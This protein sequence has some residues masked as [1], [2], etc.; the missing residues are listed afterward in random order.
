MHG[1]SV[2]NIWHAV[3][4]VGSTSGPSSS[5]RGSC[6]GINDFFF[7]YSISTAWHFLLSWMKRKFVLLITRWNIVFYC[8]SSVLFHFQCSFF[9]IEVWSPTK[10]I[11]ILYLTHDLGI[12][13][14]Y[15]HHL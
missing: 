12:T 4:F 14:P 5:I 13:N 8:N 11:K 6:P 7:V 9:L 10:A 15:Y 3:G 2:I 1:W